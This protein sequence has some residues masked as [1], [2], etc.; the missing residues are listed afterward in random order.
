MNLHRP[1]RAHQSRPSHRTPHPVSQL[2][3]LSPRPLRAKDLN[4]SFNHNL[5]APSQ[6]LS[7]I[8]SLISDIH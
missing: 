8:C 6:P 5:S 4:R 3:I 2:F 1:P 7:D